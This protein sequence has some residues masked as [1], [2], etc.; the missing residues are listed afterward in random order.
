[1]SHC[2]LLHIFCDANCATM[3][4]NMSFDRLVYLEQL[5]ASQFRA[6]GQITVVQGFCVFL[7][8][9]NSKRQWIMA[10]SVFISTKRALWKIINFCSLPVCYGILPGDCPSSFCG[11]K[12]PLSATSEQAWSIH[13]FCRL[14]KAL[15]CGLRIVLPNHVKQHSSVSKDSLH[16]VK[17]N[18]QH[19]QDKKTLQR[20][21]LNS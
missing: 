14:R 4:R 11:D 16:D 12:P 18:R 3:S 10:V 20:K 19:W 17:I 5:W 21:Q 2:M 15:S 8:S 7:G 6:S 9:W 13:C 1:M